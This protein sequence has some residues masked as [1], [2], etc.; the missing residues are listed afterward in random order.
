M[1]LLNLYKIFNTVRYF[2]LVN[3][4]STPCGL[5]E[6]PDNGRVV[7]SEDGYYAR[8]KCN[9]GYY[10]KKWTR[11]NYRECTRWGLWTGSP[12]SCNS[13]K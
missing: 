1:F 9:L 12:H 5:L 3:N 11:I 13:C 6:T 7:Y 10:L 4:S 2:L 8:Y